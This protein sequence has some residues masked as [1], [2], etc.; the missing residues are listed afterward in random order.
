MIRRSFE[1]NP[2][3]KQETRSKHNTS[4]TVMTERDI[5]IVFD[6]EIMMSNNYFFFSGI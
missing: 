5:C 1:N 4:N 6:F 2:V 3:V